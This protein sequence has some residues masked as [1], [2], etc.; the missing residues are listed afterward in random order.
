MTRN[1]SN[2]SHA[3]VERMRQRQGTWR[4]SDNL[5]LIVGPAG[6][7]SWLFRYMKNGV[8]HGMGL[9]SADLFTLKD[10]RVRA[11]GLRKMLA[12]GGDP[13]E[14]KRS[15]KVADKLM[16]ARSIT[17]RECARRYIEARAPSWKNAKHVAQ[18]QGTFFGT[19]KRPEPV[20]AAINDLPVSAIDTALALAVL[21]PVWQRTPE[22][23]SRIRQRCEQ[24]IAWATAREYRDGSNP[25]AWRGHLDTMLAEPAK[26][27]RSKH[28]AALPYAEM[29]AFM[30]ELRSID[31]LPARALEFT[32]L[33]A[34]RTGEV[35][36]ATWDEID[37]DAGVWTI[38]AARMKMQR[39]HRVPLSE[40]VLA[41]LRALPRD[42]KVFAS[43]PRMGMLELLKVMRPAA[44]VHG[45]RSSFR[46]W[47]S[48][49]TGYAHE[50][51]E[52]AL[53]HAVS[54]AVVRSYQRGD[55]FDK[56]VRLMRDWAQYC[57]STPITTSTVTPIRRARDA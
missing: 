7:A 22:S 35:V 32:I 21:E 53:A 23:A 15:K 4:V 26:L 10:A 40:G 51:N 5:Y 16:A 6:N 27:R 34:A 12:E 30:A 3:E 43:L 33:T 56:R 49:Q 2:L 46:T 8:A 55:L 20:T 38:P 14:A 28:F 31:S 54:D 50:V 44:T 39:E 11:L 57:R 9:G 42:G 17:F 45:F 47:A 41:L 29:P 19:A 36:G 24:V 52:S 18:W 48:E 13:L 37:L 25:F 1:K